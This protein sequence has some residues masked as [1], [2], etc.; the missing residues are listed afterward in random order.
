MMESYDGRAMSSTPTIV[1]AAV[2]FVTG[3]GC[4]GAEPQDVLDPSPSSAT[5]SASGGTSGS[6]GLPSNNGSSGNTTTSGGAT[7]A[8]VDASGPCPDEDEPNDDRETANVLAPV[9]CGVLQPNSD[10]DFLTFVLQPTSTSLQFKF[11]G[12][13][14]LKIEVDGSSVTLGGGDKPKVPFVKGS[15]YTVEIKAT[16][17]DNKVPW[18]VELI[19]Q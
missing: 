17:C 6:S 19:E 12:Q 15:R 9:R 8:S 16:A 10:S 2:A 11:S 18:R 4:T 3:L 1:L 14:T 7:D 5:A 13:V